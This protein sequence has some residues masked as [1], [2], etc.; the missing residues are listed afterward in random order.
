MTVGAALFHVGPLVQLQVAA[1][2]R[3]DVNAEWRFGRGLSLMAIGQN[4]LDPAH[5]EFGGAGSLLLPTQ[6]PRSATLRLRWAFR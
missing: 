1:Y 3:L 6:I 2:T 5:S 4:L